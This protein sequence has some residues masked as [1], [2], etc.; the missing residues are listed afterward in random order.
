MNSSKELKIG[1]ILSYLQIALGIV[2]GIAYTPFMLR[3]LGQSEY[4]LYNTVSSTI[5]ILSLLS[6]GF[7]AS[8]I[9]YYAKYK[10]ENDNESIYKLNGLFIIMFSVIGVVAL[11]CGLF[12]SF[13]LKYVFADGL[14]AEEYKTAKI[15]MIILT[16]NLAWTFPA[17]VFASI[18]SAHEKFVFL[19]I[20][21]IGKTVLG[22][23]VHIPVL[24][25]GYGSIGM[26]VVT[27]TITLIIDVVYLL[28]VLKKLKQKFIFKNFE[29]G[30]FRSLLIFTS[31]IAINMI[32]EQINSNMGKFLLGRYRGTQT[33]AIFSIGYTLYSHF[34]TFSTAIS[35]VFT[36]RV[37]TIINNTKDD[38]GKQKSQLTQLFTKVGRVQFLILGLVCSG[39]VFFGQTFIKFWVGDGYDESYYIGL[40]LILPAMIPLIQNVGIE[41]QRAQN[42]HKFRSLVYLGMA[43]INL[44]SS[45]FLCQ[46]Y[47]AIGPAIG[48]GI[49]LILA[50]GIA[51]NIY[52]HKS[53]NINVVYFWGQ[54]LK[55]TLGLI[56]P[57]A[58]GIL[59]IKYVALTSI[60]KMFLWIVIYS[61][62]YCVSVWLLSMNKQEKGIIK[63]FLARRK[64]VAKS[65]EQE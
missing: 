18:I 43:I 55:M 33:V 50:N 5:A 12:L 20:L 36:P 6:L 13:N 40:L 62:V 3:T 39:F 63:K 64:K 31:F 21:G 49:S 59:I 54:I 4:G 52:Y 8:Y 29:K 25:A 24:L 48:T 51:I 46:R 19:K 11:A 28:F 56:I 17:S 44:V 61:V 10:K 57:I 37:H 53:C 9:R 47:G 65:T 35:G 16:F 32:V 38:L 26:V 2:I 41:I 7:N 30:I 42:K 60:W 27:V 22:P 14:T 58:L 34:A 15:L 45:I 23:L 1:S